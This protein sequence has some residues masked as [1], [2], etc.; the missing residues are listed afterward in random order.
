[1]NYTVH[2][3]CLSHAGKCRHMNQDNFI[4]N[5]VFMDD[6][7]GKLTFPLTGRLTRGHPALVGVFD[8]M[9]GEECGEIASLLAAQYAAEV[10]VGERPLEALLKFCKDANER[11]CGY[12]TEHQISKMGTTAAL[13]AFTNSKITLCNIGDSKIFRFAEKKL[14]QISVDHCAASA[15]G[16]KPP[17]FQYLGIPPSELAIEPYVARG[18]YNDGDVYLLCS[19]GLT[20]MVITET[21]TQI[22]IK[23][24]FD[25]A[26]N[27]LLDKALE[28]G[29]K[30]NITII[31]CKVMREK[32]SL[33]GRMLQL[34]KEKGEAGHGR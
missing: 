16:T 25:E 1:M 27:K 32:H 13:L 5:G 26:A 17:L 15:Y 31:L 14:E 22:L 23:T 9:G 24:E 28:N 8:G 30:D 10:F 7:T 33:L 18:Q 19:D 2:Y 3:S 6:R 34:R 29:G 11:I 4:C 12:A 21:I 20:D